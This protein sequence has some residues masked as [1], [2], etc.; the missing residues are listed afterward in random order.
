MNNIAV[1]KKA[2]THLAKRYEEQ[3]R[4]VRREDYK[5]MDYHPFV[6]CLADDVVIK[7]TCP[8]DTPLY[9]EELR[10][11]Q[12]VAKKFLG[13]DWDMHADVTP[14]EYLEMDRPLEYIGSGDRVVVLGAESFTVKKT[15]VV[16]GPAEFAMVLDFRD[17]LIARYLHIE[18]HS[19]VRDALRE[20]YPSS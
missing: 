5:P 6:E 20:I 16:I 12:V 4:G 18:D 8:P 17:G 15:G 13:G 7:N 2:M 14:I 19:E 1:A 3:H 11:K 10:S 9:S